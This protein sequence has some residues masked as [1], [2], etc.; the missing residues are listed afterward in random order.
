MNRNGINACT[1]RFLLDENP[2]TLSSSGYFSQRGMEHNG[3]RE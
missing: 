3:R 2:D 1:Y